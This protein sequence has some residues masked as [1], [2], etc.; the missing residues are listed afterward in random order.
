MWSDAHLFIGEPKQR[1][2]E[3]AHLLFQWKYIALCK[4]VP[5]LVLLEAH[6]KNAHFKM[7]VIVHNILL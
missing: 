5:V 2:K 4:R 6:I 7:L 3:W 1:E